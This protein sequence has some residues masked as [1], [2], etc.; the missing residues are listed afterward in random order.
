MKNLIMVVLLAILIMFV[1]MGCSSSESDCSTVDW[2]HDYFG[3]FVDARPPLM[4]A[5]TIATDA[6]QECLN[7]DCRD[8]NRVAWLVWSSWPE[9]T[10]EQLDIDSIELDACM[11]LRDVQMASE[12]L[13]S[14][15][16]GD[17]EA[18]S[19]LADYLESDVGFQEIGTNEQELEKMFRLAAANPPFIQR[20]RDP[21]PRDGDKWI[22]A[23][24]GLD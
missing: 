19:A 11:H 3:A 24:Y 15:R 22:L 7:G 23:M 9:V 18:L 10:L 17:Y 21:D 20:V 1:V 16:A 4:S 2:P 13:A 12:F 14:C 5:F 6:Y 8:I